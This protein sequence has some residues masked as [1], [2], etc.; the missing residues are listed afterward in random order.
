MRACSKAC[1]ACPFVAS[2]IPGRLADYTLD[3]FISYMRAEVPFPCHQTMP[4]QDLPVLEAV[5]R[6]REG[7]GDLS[8]CAGYL[9]MLRKSHCLPRDRALQTLVLDTEVTS[10]SLDWLGFSLHHT[11]ERL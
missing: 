9:Q 5:R 11:Q 2:S 6:L 10:D 3:D 4:P 1:N 7:E 8:V